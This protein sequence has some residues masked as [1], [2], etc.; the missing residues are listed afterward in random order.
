M[1]SNRFNLQPSTPKCKLHL[2]ARA[3]IG[4]LLGRKQTSGFVECHMMEMMGQ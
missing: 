1:R 2:P 3:K 4:L